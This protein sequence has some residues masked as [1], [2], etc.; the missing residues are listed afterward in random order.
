MYQ[1]R[2]KEPR[3][4]SVV[5]QNL[6][7]SV[8]HSGGV[9]GMF[10]RPKIATWMDFNRNGMG[11]ESE[12]RHR[13]G[14]HLLLNLSLEDKDVTNIVAVV[15]NARPSQSGQYRHGV[16]FDFQAN[17]H[18]RSKSLENTIVDI[19]ATLKNILASSVSPSEPTSATSD[20]VVKLP[21]DKN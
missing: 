21:R 6:S 19:E 16:C 8:K 1:E 5:H 18:M 11:F 4:H 13:I 20:T 12:D 2:R 17:G 3:Y 15:C 9:L 7:V 14:E 10:S